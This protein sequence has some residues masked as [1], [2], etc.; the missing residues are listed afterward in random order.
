MEKEAIKHRTIYLD[1]LRVLA[2]T[3]VMMVHVSAPNWYSTDVNDY[4]WKV[5]NF[6][7]SIVQYS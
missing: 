4:D 3:A 6:Y 5:F 7:D 2:T 1:H